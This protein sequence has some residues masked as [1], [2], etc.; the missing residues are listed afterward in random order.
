MR[1]FRMLHPDIWI[2][3]TSIQIKIQVLLTWYYEVIQDVTSGYLNLHHIYPDQNPGS[4]HLIL[5]GYSGCYIRIS[6]SPPHL[7]RSK[8]RFYSPDTMRLFRMLHKDIWISTTSIQVRTHLI[9]WGYSGCYIRISGSPPHLSRSK[10]RSVLTW[11]YE[12]IQRVT[13]GYL[14]LH[15]IYPDQNPDPYSPDTVRLFSMLH[16][17]IWISTTSIQIKNPDP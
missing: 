4:T 8:S 17:D 12:V 15:H 2:S 6:G 7:S 10:S 1:L 14:D 13:S 11:Y 16:P 3:T 5:W 9:L